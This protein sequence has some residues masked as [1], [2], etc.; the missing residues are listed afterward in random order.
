MWVDI[1]QPR[2]RVVANGGAALRNDAAVARL[3]VAVLLRRERGGNV[4]AGNLSGKAVGLSL[5]FPLMLCYEQLPTLL[6]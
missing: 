5:S 1:D 2:A 3:V 6:S 4:E